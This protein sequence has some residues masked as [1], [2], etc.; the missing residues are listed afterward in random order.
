MG[1][2]APQRATRHRERL[3]HSTKQPL[4]FVRLP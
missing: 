2:I 3:L 4:S 1:A